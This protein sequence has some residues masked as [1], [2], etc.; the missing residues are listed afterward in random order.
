L[1]IGTAR[2]CILASD[3]SSFPS[4]SDAA[5]LLHYHYFR[6][7]KSKI[8][9]EGGERGVGKGGDGRFKGEAKVDG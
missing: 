5:T 1:F 7:G 4:P 2:V 3:V 6:V 8:E 9:R